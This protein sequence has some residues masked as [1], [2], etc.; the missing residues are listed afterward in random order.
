MQIWGILGKVVP[1]T[2][3]LHSLLMVTNYIYRWN[4]GPHSYKN[5]AMLLV[6]GQTLELRRPNPLCFV[7]PFD[8]INIIYANIQN[9]LET[10]VDCS[11]MCSHHSHQVS[12]D[13]TWHWRNNLS[14]TWRMMTADPVNQPAPLLLVCVS[15]TITGQPRNSVFI[16][17]V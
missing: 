6:T 15:R 16:R 4:C 5:L 13:L 12:S 10:F 17:R 9:P 14:K 1:I 2:T 8:L 7:S 3:A 11:P